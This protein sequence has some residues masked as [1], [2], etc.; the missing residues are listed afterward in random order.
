MAK[1]IGIDLGTTNSCVAIMEGGQVRVIEN[2]EGDR[3]TPSV[4]AF[5]KDA[6][7]LVGV[8]AKRQ[9]VT[10]SQHT[11]HA[12]KRLIGRKFTDAEVQKDIGLVPYK[13]VAADNGDAWVEVQGRKMS[14]QEIS[15]KV[16]MKMKKTAEDYL[17]ESVTEAVITVPAYFN[18]SQRQA[19]KDAGRIA[20]LEVKRIINEPTA[21]ALAY[22]LD[23][24]GA[25]RKI[26][27]Y[28]LGGGTFDISIIEIAE[29][30]G[31]KQFEVLA[32]NGDT[33]LGGEDF[34]KRLI[35]YVIDEFNK[36]NGVDL[37]K[38]PIALQRIKS[39]A[40]RAK[41]ELSSAQ[42]T[43]INEPYITMANGAPVHLTMRVTRAKLE[44]LVDDLVRKT[45][46][47]CKTA[48]ADAG[49]KVSDIQEVI[50]VG[51]QTRMPKVQDAVKAFFGKEP[52]KDVNPDE[53]V[54]IGAAIQGAVLS[55]QVK[56]VLLLDV[57]P[58]SLGIETLG[59]VMT[60][61][62]EKNTTIP[63]KASQVFS[64][65]E[66]NQTAVTVHVLQG[67]RER[68]AANKSLA[69]FDLAGIEPA[70]RGMP[71]VE[72]TFDIDANGI[73]HVSAKDKKTG[74]EQRI[75]I[76]AGSGLSEEE[77]QRM[78]RDAEANREEDKRFHELV[79][80]RNKADALVH[81]T[82][83]LLKEHGGKVPGQQAGAIETAIKDL[84]DAM[85]SDDKARIEA[86]ASALEQAAQSLAAAAQA[87]QGGGE[88]GPQST[89]G[90]GAQDDVVDA[91]FTEVKD[92][93]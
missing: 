15:A 53:A 35:D 6:E 18:D 16:L 64:T 38:D 69:K 10:N 84:E 56:D 51:G 81:A 47:P 83:T 33:F 36:A 76:K 87:G 62:I 21:A 78:V 31:E 70:P 58:L 54:A 14:P 26:A 44:A 42:Q 75:E 20:G 79:G 27:V 71:Q 4:V 29:V 22:G 3:T 30:D 8:S 17:G 65:A 50:L 12:V 23:K 13:I 11:L 82:R 19:T 7:V 61:L 92:K 41:I 55:G 5:T 89:G 32:T 85:K 48:I 57:T 63:T 49:L 77:I 43:D 73:M 91:E 2:S 68:A 28:D 93:K 37:S 80:A 1:I 60:K 24:K 25:D 46:E 59:G 74:K 9:A 66:D 67:E 90:A 52:R 39:A 45:I 40:E 34:D 72:V 88:A 86:K